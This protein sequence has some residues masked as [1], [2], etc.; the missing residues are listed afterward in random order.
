MKASWIS[1]I[2]KV[3]EQNEDTVFTDTD[4]GI[5][6]LADGMGGAAG[7]EI[8]SSLAVRAACDFLGDQL[9]LAEPAS[10]PRLLAD[11]LASAHSALSRKSQE[12][13]ELAGMGT[14]LEILV[15]KGMEAFICHVGDSRVYLMQ[16]DALEQLTTDDNM[17]S[18]L[19]AEHVTPEEIPPR[20]RHILT[21]AVGASDTLIPEVRTVALQ[22]KDVLLLCSDGLTGM[23][24]DREMGEI[25]RRHR[26][27]LDGAAAALV[28]TAND[29]G[30]YDNVSLILVDPTPVPD[31][32]LLLEDLTENTPRQ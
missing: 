18:L 29:R 7:G 22:P 3:R 24:S 20:A 19:L 1:D 12:E 31:E 17:A 11:A 25:I 8:A 30:G 6:L 10:I 21:Q 32:V 26:S 2:G 27:D 4:K 9:A 5:F 16:N 13:P 14:T 15:V 28:R 23:L